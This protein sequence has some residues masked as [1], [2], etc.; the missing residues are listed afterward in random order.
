M[1]LPLLSFVTEHLV[2]R[3]GSRNR[4]DHCL[5]HVLIKLFL[6][7]ICWKLGYLFRALDLYW[8][9]LC[10]FFF[11]QHPFHFS[12][13]T[14]KKILTISTLQSFS[15]TLN[16]T[17]S[18]R[19]SIVQVQISS[20]AAILSMPPASPTSPPPFE[21]STGM[22][23]TSLPS[24][25]LSLSLGQ[26]D[27]GLIIHYFYPQTG[28]PRT[29]VRTGCRPWWNKKKGATAEKYAHSFRKTFIWSKLVKVSYFQEQGLKVFLEELE[30][31]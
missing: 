13:F 25:L 10:F 16:G 22:I 23:V 20:T 19:E 4:L 1:M 15:F 30:A 17:N 3:I 27:W 31:R 7:H 11:G 6:L 18:W 24:T 21:L 28:S 8:A 5:L 26:W 29:G 9:F 14:Q 2:V 12:Y